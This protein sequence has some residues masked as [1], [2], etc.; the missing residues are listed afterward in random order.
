MMVELRLVL[1][2]HN[3][4]RVFEAKHTHDLATMDCGNVAV[5]LRVKTVECREIRVA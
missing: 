5:A 4:V 3:G 2:R 1:A